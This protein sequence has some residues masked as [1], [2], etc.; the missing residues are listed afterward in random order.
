MNDFEKIEHLL[1]RKKFEELSPTE[2]KEV[3]GYFENANDYNDMRDTLMQVKSTLAADKILI[4]PNVELKEK[5]LQ[6]FDKTYTNQ[7]STAGKTRPF[8]KNIAFQWSAAASV[9]IIISIS[10]FG[11]INNMSGKKSDEMAINYKSN[12]NSPVEETSI[13]SGETSTVTGTTGTE[14]DGEERV[15]IVN[16]DSRNEEMSNDESD[17]KEVYKNFFVTEKDVNKGES[18]DITNAPVTTNSENNIL[19]EG[20]IDNT[21]LR[22]VNTNVSKE[23][24]KD[25]DRVLTN[26]YR[27]DIGDKIQDKSMELKT[28]I[29]TNSQSQTYGNTTLISK[30]QNTTNKKDYWGKKKNKNKTKTD[31]NKNNLGNG[32]LAKDSVITKAD[33][34]K[35]DSNKNIL[36]N[37]DSIQ[38]DENQKKA[39]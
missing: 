4:K 34:L 38:M 32:G 11:Y 35:L 1:L 39:E 8:Y 31:S 9:V 19:Q 26:A 7:I 10:I 28:T 29:P 17:K 33:S 18:E 12:K 16:P 2:V 25:A 22:G 36:E 24:K 20:Y 30:D 6:Q 5:L 27:D 13:S 15:I 3:N 37:K 14:T 23:E 21:T